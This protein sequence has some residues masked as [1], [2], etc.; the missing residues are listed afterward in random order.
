MISQNSHRI[1]SRDFH[2]TFNIKAS[3]K[4]NQPQPLSLKHEKH[5][6][7]SAR[8]IFDIF[9]KQLWLHCLWMCCTR[10]TNLL[11]VPPAGLWQVISFLV[12]WDWISLQNL[13]L[14]STVFS[15]EPWETTQS[16]LHNK[17]LELLATCN[18]YE[19]LRNESIT[20]VP[21]DVTTQSWSAQRSHPVNM[22]PWNWTPQVPK[23]WTCKQP[24]HQ[25]PDLVEI[26]PGRQLYHSTSKR[27]IGVLYN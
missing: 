27:T 19:L 26:Q 1:W 25:S 23:P 3:K 22:A 8:N 7:K 2:R 4:K 18:C 10:M 11:S 5:A 14:T 24:L 20:S 21:T 9:N 16:S 12:N 17:G 6:L 15:T 13:H